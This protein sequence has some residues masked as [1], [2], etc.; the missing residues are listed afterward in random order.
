M[1]KK[2]HK[3]FPAGKLIAVVLIALIAACVINPSLLFFLTEEQQGVVADFQ[4]TYF[5]ARNPL[6]G[7]GGRLRP[8]EPA[9]P[10]PASG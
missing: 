1:E 10:G 3:K 4:A 8:G 9:V 6:Q 5:T 7:E 2:T